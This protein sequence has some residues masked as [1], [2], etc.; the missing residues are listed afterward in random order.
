M[1]K[2]EEKDLKQERENL[3]QDIER[4]VD[5]SFKAYRQAVELLDRLTLDS[6]AMSAKGHVLSKMM[7]YGEALDSYDKAIQNSSSW[8][9]KPAS[10]LRAKA[11]IGKGNV[12]FKIGKHEEALRCY[13]E[14]MVAFPECKPCLIGRI[15]DIK[16]AAGGEEGAARDEAEAIL[17]EIKA[18]GQVKQDETLGK[19]ARERVCSEAWQ[20]REIYLSLMRYSN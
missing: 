1:L 2:Q 20:D 11:L 19:A 5:L 14:A 8:P 16:E 12:L 18:T 6:D 15:K 3:K 13:K 10:A 9:K 17:R 7:R 4:Q